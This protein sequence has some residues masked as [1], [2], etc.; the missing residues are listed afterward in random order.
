[1]GQD[2]KA[3]GPDVG[4]ALRKGTVVS[5]QHTPSTPE[6]LILIVEISTVGIFCL[7]P[8]ARD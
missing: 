1:M 3:P 2:G 7:H 4:F 8:A 5:P 6:Q